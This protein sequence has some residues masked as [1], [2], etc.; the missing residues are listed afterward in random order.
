MSDPTEEVWVKVNRRKGHRSKT[1]ISTVSSATPLPNNPTLSLEQVQQDH[2]RIATQWKSSP[3]YGQL[4]ALL[5]RH[6]PGPNNSVAA[7]TKAICFGLGSFDTPPDGSWERTRTAHV[8]LAAFLALVE[9]LQSKTGCQIRCIFQD[10][11]FNSIDK[12][13]IESLGHEAVESPIGFQLVDPESLVFGVHL[14][15]DVYSQ[16]IATHIPAIF[17]GTSYQVWEDV[18]GAENLDW[19]RM[20][21]LDQLC[22]KA[23]FPKNQDDSGFSTTTIHWRQ[24][25]AKLP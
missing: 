24:E 5:S 13:F 7:V 8:Q 3:S 22:V 12:A 16:V 10:P 4:Q 1:A 11:V 2:D 25:N 21:E 20:R 18:H 14:Y 17:V 23:E 15:K 19:A 9:H 6:T